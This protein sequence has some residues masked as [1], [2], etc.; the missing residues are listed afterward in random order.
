MP[1]PKRFPGAKL[2]YVAVAATLALLSAQSIHAAQN[3]P[4]ASA[5]HTP[6]QFADAYMAAFNKG[7]KAALNKLRYATAG[8]SP[9]QEMMDVF[10]D[11]ELEAHTQYSLYNLEP[12][13]PDAMKPHMGPDGNMYQFNMKPTNVLKLT[14][15]QKNGTSST[16]FP[17]GVKDGIYYQ[18]GIERAPGA[19]PTFSFGWQ[20]FTPPQ[21]HWSVNMPNEPEP[22]KAA[23]QL[24]RGKDALNDPDVYGVVKNTADIKTFQH[25]FMCGEEGK[26]LT[27]KDNQE[28][29]RAA[30]TTY[31]PETL[32]KWFS[33]GKKNLDDAVDARTRLSDGKLVMQKEI[34]LNGA[35]GREFEVTDK[36]GTVCLGRVYWVK[37]ALYELTV[38]SK[39][40]TPDRVKA[41]TFLSSLKVE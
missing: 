21:G 26:R 37:D 35:P 19:A 30:C 34:E 32:Q 31:T 5:P 28:Q 41:E 23:L 4:K 11:A 7:D 10:T 6:Q 40:P 9:M 27:A 13:D 20:R 3:A 22:G 39:K 36:D 12:V 8:T 15:A 29:Y 1:M 16:S 24:D 25:M 17:I 33:D 2:I 38:E 14:A 18:V